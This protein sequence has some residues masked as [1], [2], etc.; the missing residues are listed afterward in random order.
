[1]LPN[2]T[3]IADFYRLG[4]EALRGLYRGGEARTILRRLLSEA[5]GC[6]DTQVL[7]LEPD[8]ELAAEAVAQLSHWLGRLE[9][10]EPL[11]YILGYTYFYGERLR[12]APGALIPRPETEELVELAVARIGSR[13]SVL[14]V[15]EVGTGSGCIPCAL[16]VAW[17]AQLDLT[18]WD[19]ST[20][21][22]A[23]ARC[24][25]RLYSERYGAKLRALEQ[26]LFAAEFPPREPFELIIS[27]PPYIH[28]DEAAQMAPT[29]LDYEPS[30]A[31]FAPEQRPTIFYEGIAA[32]AQRG[33]LSSGGYIL[34]ELNPRYA[35]QTLERMTS[36]LG[37][38]VAQANL[39]QD[40]SGKERFVLIQLK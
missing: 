37:G 40:L 17:G 38:Q 14:R 29:V 34:A 28:P 31:L 18:S 36:M 20:E 9:R 15:L 22:L 8:L 7:M 24:N 21:A 11:Q 35:A 3:T 2:S 23:I 32:L 6:S 1:M 39:Y 5:L 13:G 4:A 10:A 12:V 16:A 19:I 30:T 27:N 33:Y 26:D 25:M